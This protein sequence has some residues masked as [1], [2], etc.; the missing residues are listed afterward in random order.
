MRLELPERVETRTFL[1]VRAD[2]LRVAG[3]ASVRSCDRRGAKFVVGVEL[4]QKLRTLPLQAPA[5]LPKP[6]DQAPACPAPSPE[7]A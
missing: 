5:P 4:V 7:V 3:A 6:P 1:N 2:S